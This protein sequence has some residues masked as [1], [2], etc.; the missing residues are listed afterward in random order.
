MKVE[1]LHEAGCEYALL[2]MSLS[3]DQKCFFPT[4]YKVALKLSKKDGGHNKFMES[5]QVWIDITAP[6]YWWQQFDTYRVGTTKQSGSTMHTIMRSNLTQ[7][8]F[9]E[10]IHAETLYHLNYLIS[11]KDFDQLKNELP[12]GFLQRR[13][14][15]T[16]YKVLRNMILQRGT[17]KLKEWQFF[18]LTVRSQV[19]YKDFLP[20]IKE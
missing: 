5:M 4:Q 18:I 12:E 19:Q 16:N 8:D 20:K 6:R 1:I 14:V 10:P 11:I 7:D 15:N 2:G 17:H 13:I 3:Y 9:A